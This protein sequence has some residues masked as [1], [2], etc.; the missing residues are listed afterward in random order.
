MKPIERYII[1]FAVSSLVVVAGSYAFKFFGYP[2][3]SSSSDWAAL[4]EYFGGIVGPILSFM[5]VWLVIYEAIE[6]RMNFLDSK[7]LQLNSQEQ[8]NKQIELLTPRPEIIYYPLAVG[9][10]V[11][12]VVENIGNATA[13]NLRIDARFDEKIEDYVL[14]AFRRMGNPSYFPPKYKMSVRAGARL[15]DQTVMGLPPH[16]VSVRYSTSPDSPICDEKVYVVDENMLTSLH[17]EPDYNDVLRRIVD[18]LRD[19]RGTL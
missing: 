17:S 6:S 15:I 10:N 14:G 18:Q 16:S 19:R 4:G 3:S 13:Y 2:I 1:L 5:L 11:Y 12:A 7:Q 8:I 9:T